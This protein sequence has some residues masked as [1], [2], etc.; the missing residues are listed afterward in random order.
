MNKSAILR[1]LEDI[2]ITPV[3]KEDLRYNEGIRAAM[4]VI[5]N[6]KK[7]KQIMYRV[8]KEFI[9]NGQIVQYRYGDYDN[10]N[11]ANEVALQIR[12][13]ENVFSTS[14]VEIEE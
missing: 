2:I 4:M 5:E 14:V 11:L 10:R 9:E 1:Q 8:Y 13:N 3:S 12:D 7:P 6:Y